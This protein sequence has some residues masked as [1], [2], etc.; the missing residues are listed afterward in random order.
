MTPTQLETVIP[1]YTRGMKTAI[2]LPDEVFR[3]A[4]DRAAQ[5]GMSRSE[6]FARAATDYLDK[7]DSETLTQQ[8]NDA[9]DIVDADDGASQDAVSRGRLPLE[10]GAG[11][12]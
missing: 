7:L 8:V 11:E 6:L 9:L 4:T 3:R 1:S 2:S 5:L 12:W 10:S